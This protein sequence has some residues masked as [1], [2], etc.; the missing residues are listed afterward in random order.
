MFSYC[1]KKIRMQL[2]ESP[3]QNICKAYFCIWQRTGFS[4]DEKQDARQSLRCYLLSWD[5]RFTDRLQP[6]SA[7]PLSPLCSLTP[8]QI[9]HVHCREGK[10]CLPSFRP[11][12]MHGAHLPTAP[13][14]AFPMGWA[15]VFFLHFTTFSPRTQP[16]PGFIAL[17]FT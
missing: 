11:E 4:A 16:F 10:F 5:R 6:G 7:L 15:W 12:T 3:S 9:S 8:S 1:H 13:A 2:N 17:L 14:P